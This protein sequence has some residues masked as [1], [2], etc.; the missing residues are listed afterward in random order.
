MLINSLCHGARVRTLRG[1]ESTGSVLCEHVA[2]LKERTLC[3][4]NKM[5]PQFCYKNGKQIKH[6]CAVQ[7]VRQYVSLAV[8]YYHTAIFRRRN[9]QKSTKFKMI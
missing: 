4:K 1:L 8:S 3:I 9:T 2:E 5:H 7:S 6:Y